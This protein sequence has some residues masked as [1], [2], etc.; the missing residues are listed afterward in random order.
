MEDTLYKEIILD[1]Y[2][3][4]LNKKI[5]ADFDVEERGFN[6]TCGDDLTIRLKF[7]ADGAI[8]DIG[9]QGA[10]CAISEAAMSLITDE[11]KGKGR[12]VVQAMG[13]SNIMD[14]LGTKIIPTRMQCALLGLKAIQKAITV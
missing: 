12:D 3:Q 13:Q 11:V 9:Y 7:G 1:L 8:Q 6:P 10:G 14:L 5:L 4:P 2:R